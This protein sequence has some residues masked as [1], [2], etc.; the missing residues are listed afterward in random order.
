MSRILRKQ[1]RK[2]ELTRE[3]N[4]ETLGEIRREMEMRR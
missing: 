3:I 1:E 2:V 4:G